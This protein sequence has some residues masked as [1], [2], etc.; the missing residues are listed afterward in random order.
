MSTVTQEI[1]DLNYNVNAK[2]HKPT[3]VQWKDQKIIRVHSLKATVKEIL[4]VAHALDV[5]KIGLV[6][7]PSTGKTTLA[8]CLAHLIHKMSDIPF[9]FRVFGEEQF[10]NMEQ[11]LKTLEPTN[12]IL[13]FHDLSFLENKKMIEQVKA[14][15]T[16]IR[17]LKT[18]V[19]IILIYDYHYTLGL[20]KYL[21]QANFR[22]FTSLGSSEF[23]NMIK[24][25]GTKYTMRIQDFNNKYVEMTTKQKCTFKIGATNYFVYNYKN[26]FVVCLFWN[27]ARLRYVIFPKREWLDKL[28]DK[29]DSSNGQLVHSAIPIRQFRKEAEFTC[30]E[31]AFRTAVKLEMLENGMNVFAPSVVQAKRYLNKAMQAKQISLKELALD[32]GYTITKT[33]LKKKLE[34]LVA[35]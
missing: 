22:Y 12:Y 16:K 34:G 10:L 2:E 31:S 13:Y 35:T 30:G 4:Q 29:C 21:R 1:V 15:I 26:P 28:C 27:N 20:D 18:D 24:I 23:D 32:Y 19:K 9:A 33:K 11:T 25:V 3:I 5:V 6:G 7:E 8:M 14:S 17:H